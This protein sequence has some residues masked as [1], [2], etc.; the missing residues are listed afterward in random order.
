MSKRVFRRWVGVLGAAA[1]AVAGP[2]CGSPPQEAPAS[3]E[4]AAEETAAPSLVT[5]AEH[6]A[7][8]AKLTVQFSDDFNQAYGPPDQFDLKRWTRMPTARA[9]IRDGHWL[10]EVERAPPPGPGEAVLGGFGTTGKYFNPGLAGTNGAEVTVGVFSHE[11]YPE[12]M[13]EKGQ[14]VQAWSITLG[15][16]HGFVGGQ[17]DE[18][19]GIQLHFDLLRDDGLF[20]YLVR[21]LRPDDFEKYPRDKFGTEEGK[22]MTPQELRVAHEAA[23]ATGGPYV[24]VPCMALATRVYREPAEIADLLER[25][26]RWGVY[27][28]DDANTVYWTLDGQ[29]M[30]VL[31]ISGYFSSSPKSVEDG[32]LISIMGVATNQLNVWKMDDLAF[33][34]SP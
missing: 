27:L 31:D 6:E 28:T 33:Y 8:K 13:N 10:L 30:D 22:T 11:D 3:E 25:P 18:D 14:L 34:A 9:R 21:G 24:T 15:S 23:I 19:R 7:T 5:Q 16:W 20:V 26:R 4:P 29:V 32:A 2:G 17:E 1:L 12:E